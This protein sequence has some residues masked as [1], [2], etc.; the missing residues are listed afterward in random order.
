M[1]AH[2]RRASA[3]AGAL[4][5]IAPLSARGQIPDGWKSYSAGTVA[6]L[7]PA[8]ISSA[9]WYD[10]NTPPAS[11]CTGWQVGAFQYFDKTSGTN[12]CDGFTAEC[13]LNVPVHAFDGIGWPCLGSITL[14][15]LTPPQIGGLDSGALQGVGMATMGAGCAGERERQRESIRDSA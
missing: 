7:Q 2:T 3:L 6:S 13:I 1:R 10:L 12:R 5:C 14:G 8:D 11:S 4:A 9:G 15:K